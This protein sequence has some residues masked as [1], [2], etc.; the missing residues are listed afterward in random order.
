MGWVMAFGIPTC[1]Q[2]F[3]A[4]LER[5][6]PSVGRAAQFVRSYH[7]WSHY[8]RE[9]VT[10][11]RTAEEDLRR[12]GVAVRSGV[13]LTEL[14]ELFQA[15]GY[16]VLTVF[17]HWDEASGAVEL[18]DGFAD[19]A[20]MLA[21]VPSEYEGIIDLCV[22]HPTPLVDALQEQR[23]RAVVKFTDSR[24]VPAFWLQ[25]YRAVAYRWAKGHGW[26]QAVAD[27]IRSWQERARRL[28]ALEET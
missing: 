20:A 2:E 28:R 11:L 26:V 25:F 18:R 16:E 19:P 12:A 21:V 6:A 27:E 8:E 1:R 7:G 5:E 4:L 17:A 3:R 15:G 9:V 14:R 13:G 10:P 22:C 24:A 23:R